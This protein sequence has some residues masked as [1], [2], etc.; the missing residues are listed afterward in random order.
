MKTA[1]KSILFVSIFVLASCK[2]GSQTSLDYIYN[3]KPELLTCEI[4]NKV[5]LKEAVYSFEADI[6]EHY[7]SNKPDLR[8]AY[9]AFMA[10]ARNKKIPYLKMISPQTIKIFEALKNEGSIYSNGNILNSKNEVIKCIS[11]NI[12][13]K[14]FKTTFNA[15]LST[16]SLRQDIIIPPL[17]AISRN[18]LTD[19]YLATY[20]AL[21]FYYK[22]MYDIDLTKVADKPKSKVD[23]NKTPKTNSTPGSTDKVTPKIEEKDPHA[24]HNH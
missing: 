24:G 8:R 16:N 2:K 13:D 10:A 22:G 9:S 4:P 11:S 15:L 1:L 21:E 3:D 18:M 6:T 5:L 14:G 23:F 12:K 20:A 19:K 7:S 17:T